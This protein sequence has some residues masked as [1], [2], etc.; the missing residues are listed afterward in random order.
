MPM[1][2]SYTNESVGLLVV[3]QKVLWRPDAP[4]AN[5]LT[6]LYMTAILAFNGLMSPIT[7]SFEFSNE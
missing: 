6:G 2:P 5:Q 4:Q 7:S 3:C 1:S